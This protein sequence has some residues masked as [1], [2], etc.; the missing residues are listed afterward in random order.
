MAQ[1]RKPAQIKTWL[2]GEP[3]LGELRAAY[4]DQW[5]IVER[6]LMAV[7]DSGDPAALTQYAKELAAGSLV[8]S[9]RRSVSGLDPVLAAMVRQRMGAH[10][11]R[12]LS[13][14][15]ATGVESGAIRFGQT[16]GAIIQDLL[17]ERELERRPVDLDAFNAAWPSLQER[18]KL[19]PLVQPRGIYC[20]YS[21]QFVREIARMIGGRDCVEIAAGDGTLARFLNQ[22][23]TPVHPTDDHSWSAVA[24][25]PEVENLD[26]GDAVKRYQPQVVL[27]SWPPADNT[28]EAAVF[29][30]ESVETY[31]VIGNRNAAGW[32]NHRAY[33]KQTQFKQR[34][35]LELG[36]L[37]LPPEL[38]PVVLVFERAA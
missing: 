31:V 17:F 2:Q 16:E 29:S 13:T 4:P 27:C 3:S 6:E 9:R 30:A 24:F 23:G 1:R 8:R 21:A 14:R 28:F 34:T 18:A 10:A 5:E 33:A 22:A 19:M 37:V 11:L 25:A 35:D 36:T 32:G 7:V 38:E 15:A 20:F 26:A 12:A